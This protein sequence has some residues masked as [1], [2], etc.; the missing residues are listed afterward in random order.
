MVPTGTLNVLSACRM[1]L[2]D[3]D[4]TASYAGASEYAAAVAEVEVR[5]AA[6]RAAGALG[7]ALG[8]GTHTSDTGTV[9]VVSESGPR[10]R[11]LRDYVPVV[12]PLLAADQPSLDECWSLLGELSGVPV[13]R[14]P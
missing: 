8:P 3:D 10:M 9:W 5:R 11:V 7:T 6:T 4:P 13:T 14:H 2:V 1:A 12:G